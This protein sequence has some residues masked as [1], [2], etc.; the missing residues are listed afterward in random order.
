SLAQVHRLL[1]FSLA[2]VHRLLP[3]SL[4][5]VH[6]LLPFSLAQVY[7]LL[8]FSLAQVYRLLPYMHLS[9]LEESLLITASAMVGSPVYSLGLVQYTLRPPEGAV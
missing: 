2:Q 9:G 3:F 8:P 5:Q 7:R 1:P 4:A 6:R